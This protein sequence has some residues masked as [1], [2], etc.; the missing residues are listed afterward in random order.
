MILQQML[1]S[2]SLSTVIQFLQE[3]GFCLP[4]RSH[5]DSARQRDMNCRL[6]VRLAWREVGTPGIVVHNLRY[7]A[8]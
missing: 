2:S 5:I 7:V 3:Q 6:G 4:D 1:L 8:R